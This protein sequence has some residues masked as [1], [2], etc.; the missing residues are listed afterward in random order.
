M[1]N[2]ELGSSMP[3]ERFS[4]TQSDASAEKVSK[5]FGPHHA[6]AK[7]LKEKYT[8]GKRIQ[9]WIC[10][11]L[12]LALIGYNG[13]H[14][15]VYFNPRN[16]FSILMC[17][18]LGV[19]LA[20]FLSGLVHWGADTWGAVDMPMFGPAFIRPFR[21]HHIDPT[22][23]TRHDWIEANG[24]NC[25]TTVPFLAYMAYWFTTRTSDQIMEGYNMSMFIYLLAIF[26][27]LTN[28]THKWSHTYFGLPW[29]IEFL[30]NVHILL[31]RKHH[32]VHHVSPH[33]SYYCITTGWLNYPLEWINFWRTAESLITKYTGAVPRSD[34]MKWASKVD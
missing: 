15:A 10:V 7:E 33:E 11:I 4:R 30:Q 20:D 1:D 18:V 14:L 34:D 27:T 22:A 29:Y 16:W 19:L 32:R 17:A 9:E 2:K 8:K 25:M 28:Q 31:P 24:D 5:R 26:V 23:I 13:I 12:C 6:G 3:R 21:E